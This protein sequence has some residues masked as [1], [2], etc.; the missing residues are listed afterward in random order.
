MISAV[1]ADT[2]LGSFLTILV[3]SG[4]YVAGL[5]LLSVAAY[6]GVSQEWMVYAS[7]F[8]FIALGAGGI[9]SCV[10][11]LGGAQYHPE[12]HVEEITRFFN[13]F[14]C[15]YKSGS[16]RRRNRRTSGPASYWRLLR[17]L[18]DYS[19]GFWHRHPR[20][21]YRLSPVR[22]DGTTRIQYSKNIAGSMGF[23]IP[24]LS[25]LSFKEVGWR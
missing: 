12:L 22:Q 6:P 9:K 24:M 25:F 18:L 10:N 11:I 4:F 13:L 17:R 16:N 15:L 3:F 8:G 14:L 21:Y 5:A 1:I 23:N 7:L 2:W 19:R 20:I